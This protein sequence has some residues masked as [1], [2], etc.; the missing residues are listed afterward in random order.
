MS[1]RVPEARCLKRRLC[2]PCPKHIPRYKSISNS[3]WLILAIFG[4]FHKMQASNTI[5]TLAKIAVPL[6]LVFRSI[7]GEHA[8]LIKSLVSA[9][10]RR[11]FRSWSG[12]APP[13]GAISS[14]SPVAP[15]RAPRNYTSILCSP[16]IHSTQDKFPTELLHGEGIRC[17][18][19]HG[20]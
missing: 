18:M 13:A 11:I 1:V 6:S 7:N 9:P 19:S 14:R 3:E 8:P 10:K 5:A 4:D 17:Q 2:K 12:F 20:G 16:R 15:A